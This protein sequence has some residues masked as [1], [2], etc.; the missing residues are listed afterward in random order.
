MCFSLSSLSF[1]ILLWRC[2]KISL[3]LRDFL[4]KAAKSTSI[5]PSRTPSRL[6]TW[7][8]RHH[9]RCS[10]HCCCW[11]NI[12]PQ[13]RV[14]HLIIFLSSSH[15]VR[16]PLMVFISPSLSHSTFDEFNERAKGWISHGIIHERRFF[17]DSVSESSLLEILFLIPT[18]VTLIN[19]DPGS[20]YMSLRLERK[21]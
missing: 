13:T 14:V 8:M 21:K 12:V 19:E 4:N 5:R 16:Y 2:D 17:V 10:F 7:E 1:L 6:R 11:A 20:L 3:M 15:C 9:L 18:Q